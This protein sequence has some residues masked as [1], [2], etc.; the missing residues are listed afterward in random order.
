MENNTIDLLKTG[1]TKFSL[2]RKYNQRLKLSRLAKKVVVSLTATAFILTAST[3]SSPAFATSSYNSSLWLSKT[4]F[5]KHI[6]E[7]HFSRLKANSV[8]SALGQSSTR[9]VSSE[10]QA[11]YIKTFVLA[12]IRWV[13]DDDPDMESERADVQILISILFAING[14]GTQDRVAIILGYVRNDI[15]RKMK[16]S[17]NKAL[18][19]L[20]KT[21]LKKEA[22]LAK[23][24]EDRQA[25]MQMARLNQIETSMQQYASLNDKAYQIGFETFNKLKE[26]EARMNVPIQQRD[27]FKAGLDIGKRSY[28]LSAAGRG[29]TAAPKADKPS[30]SSDN[31]LIEADKKTNKN[32]I[33]L[34]LID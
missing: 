27:A 2:W 16:K 33:I 12:L 18:S 25:V 32:E 23:E 19:K 20:E 34:N 7:S 31:E 8:F 11:N 5:Y 30:I 22:K 3:I 17:N 29:S 15:S 14:V 26:L 9:N 1:I 10:V 4:I 28:D 6:E 21:A 13:F 24:R